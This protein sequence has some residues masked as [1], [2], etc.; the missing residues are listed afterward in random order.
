M[1]ATRA[2][3]LVLPRRSHRLVL[4]VLLRHVCLLLFHR[5]L[6]QCIRRVVLKSWPLCCVGAPSVQRS[7]ARRLLLD[8]GACASALRRCEALTG[9]GWP[10]R[11][12]VWSGL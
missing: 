9:G 5:Q 12:G 4:F 10:K 7:W 3:L 1:L 6:L 2:V 8:V 11:C